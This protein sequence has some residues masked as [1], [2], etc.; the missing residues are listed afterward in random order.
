MFSDIKLLYLTQD[1]GYTPSCFTG[2]FLRKCLYFTTSKAKIENKS[3]KLERDSTHHY[4]ICSLGT[5]PLKKHWRKSEKG[6]ILW[7][8][9]PKWRAKL[10]RQLKCLTLNKP[11]EGHGCVRALL[12]PWNALGIALM[13]IPLY[14]LCSATSCLTINNFKRSKPST[15]QLSVAPTVIFWSPSRQRPRAGPAPPRAARAGDHRAM[16]EAAPFPGSCSTTYR[17]K[18]FISR[19]YLGMAEQYPAPAASCV[20]PLPLPGALRERQGWRR[21]ASLWFNPERKFEKPKK[22]NESECLAL[23]HE[24]QRPRKP[25]FA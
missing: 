7:I 10:Q 18:A 1:S 14:C 8:S 15:K 5:I 4:S 20:L 21:F 9:A 11:E 6:S 17:Q 2:R 12:L 23:N 22:V 3:M 16:G 13:T 19:E 25:S 24:D